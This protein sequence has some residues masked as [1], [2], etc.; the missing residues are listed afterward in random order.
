MLRRYL[1]DQ[2]ESTAEIESR[3]ITPP[4]E[5][6]AECREVLCCV[7]APHAAAIERENAEE[8]RCGGRSYLTSRCRL[9][10]QT[11]VSRPYV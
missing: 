4:S 7:Y 3:N 5:G 9:R 1:S 8:L 6:R 10:Y 2:I 11:K